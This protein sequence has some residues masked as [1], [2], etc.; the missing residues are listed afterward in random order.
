MSPVEA[1]ID[2]QCSQEDDHKQSRICRQRSRNDLQE[3][4]H[5]RLIIILFPIYTFKYPTDCWCMITTMPCMH[6]RIQTCQHCYAFSYGKGKLTREPTFCTS[7]PHAA[8]L[9]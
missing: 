5:V 1:E 6:R 3:R 2:G 7:G 9:D 4:V 8:L